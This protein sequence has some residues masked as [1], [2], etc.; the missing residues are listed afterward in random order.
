MCKLEHDHALTS[1][2]PVRSMSRTGES[3]LGL[4]DILVRLT[5]MHSHEASIADNDPTSHEEDVE[6]MEIDSRRPGARMHHKVLPLIDSAD[7]VHEYPV[8]LSA[9][10]S[11]NESAVARAAMASMFDDAIT[12]NYAG[13]YRFDVGAQEQ[14]SY[15]RHPNV[16]HDGNTGGRVPHSIH[17]NQAML[18]H[19]ACL[20]PRYS[21][22]RL[23]VSV[24]QQQ[25][26]SDPDRFKN[27]G[28]KTKST[29]GVAVDGVTA[30][31]ATPNGVVKTGF[32]GTQDVLERAIPK[33]GKSF[34]SSRRIH[35]PIAILPTE[36]K[37]QGDRLERVSAASSASAMVTAERSGWRLRYAFASWPGR[38]MVKI[39]SGHGTALHA[40]LERN[41]DPL[42]AEALAAAL[43]SP[44]APRGLRLV[45]R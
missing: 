26:A 28:I 37:R 29:G 13:A 6:K 10:S 35:D 36:G 45:R 8:K 42:A 2:M 25:L 11:Q 5:Q 30:H 21:A 41:T 27:D 34:K 39:W 40:S 14:R 22:M 31:D 20:E 23:A 44:G 7:P 4:E 15:G 3:G 19:A 38:P 16:R 24:M 32:S 17:A 33:V 9:F 1:D 43:S 12:S 18:V